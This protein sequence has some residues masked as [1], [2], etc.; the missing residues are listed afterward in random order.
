LCQ[1]A[2]NHELKIRDSLLNPLPG[3]HMHLKV[4]NE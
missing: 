4:L 2:H 3:Q 1:R